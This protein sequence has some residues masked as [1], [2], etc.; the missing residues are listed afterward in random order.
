MF[1]NQELSDLLYR[2]GATL[3]GY[4]DLSKSTED[5]LKY[6]VS[7]VVKIPAHIISSIHEGPN[8]SYYNNYHELKSELDV[9]AETGAAYIEKCG[10]RAISQTT[11]NEQEDDSY[12]T[13]MPHKTVAVSAGLGW[14]GKSALFVTK[15]YGPAVRLS[16]ILTDAPLEVA[17]PI[18]ESSC[19]NCFICTDA[20]PAGAI[21]GTAW[22]PELDRDEFYNPLACRKKA[23][24]LAAEHINEEITLCGKCVEVCPYTQNYISASKG[25]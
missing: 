1:S 14:I 15:E 18:T 22:T 2:S 6:G 3:V 12:R 23:R 7:I 25:I 24:E 10:Y 19:G 16:S 17:V 5:D 9:L 13:K 4:A 20:C 21:S 8:R 11:A